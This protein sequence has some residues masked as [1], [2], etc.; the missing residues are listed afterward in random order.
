MRVQL[1]RR[2]GEPRKIPVTVTPGTGIAWGDKAIRLG[3]SE[4]QVRAVLGEPE[5]CQDHFY[6]DS[7][8]A[9]RYDEDGMV[10]LIDFLGGAEGLIQPVVDGV[11]VFTADG[12]AVL[13]L[14]EEKNGGPGMTGPVEGFLAFPKVS[15]GAYRAKDENG[16]PYR[17]VTLA[18]GKAG[19]YDCPQAETE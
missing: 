4:A 6:F 11:A 8:L 5:I 14:L 9:I 16:K 10:V 2:P 1:K 13:S 12:D 3:D 15:V 19:Y 7:D 17:W 18:I